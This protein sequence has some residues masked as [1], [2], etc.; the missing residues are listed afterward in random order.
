MAS[1]VFTRVF[2]A[3]WRIPPFAGQAAGYAF[4]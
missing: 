2:Y 4:G 3:L 1:S